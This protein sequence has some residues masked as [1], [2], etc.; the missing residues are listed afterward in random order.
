M[1]CPECG[2]AASPQQLACQQCGLLLLNHEPL[3]RRKDDLAV[4][5]RRA[6]DQ[7]KTLCHFCRGEIDSSAVCCR[8]CGQII[9]DDFRRAMIARRR[10]QINYASWVCYTF[11]LL[12]FL[13]F[14]PVG[15]FAIGAGLVLS[16]IYYAIPVEPLVTS[17]KERRRSFLHRLFQQF[18]IERVTVPLP[19]LRSARLVFVGS[20]IIA[21]V[22]GYFA[23]FMMLQRPM[24]EILKGNEAFS[25]MAV[26]IHYEYWMIP[27]V[28][29]YDLKSVGSQ[30]T[31]I[32]VHTAFL[33]YA[34]SMK[35]SHFRRIELSFRGQPRFTMTG[36][37]FH[38][39][40]EEYQR[41]NFN[42]VVFEF[43][44]LVKPVVALPS[45]DLSHAKDALYQLHKA[46][47]GATRHAA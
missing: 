31:P 5:K 8:H 40:G 11:G 36:A 25:G 4:E 42:F 27:G 33:E 24:N 6:S 46:W 28:V 2:S 7:A 32:D 3:K 22:L 39:L 23:N 18:K 35:D 47:Y 20:P 13:I 41:K 44:K 21:L 34:R 37:D 12:V 30:Q 38:K 17:S 14:R 45:I 1:N 9:N 15:V 19:H 43:P 26:S 10:S 16:I 29:V